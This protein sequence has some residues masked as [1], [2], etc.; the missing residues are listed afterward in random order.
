MTGENTTTS[1]RGKKKKDEFTDLGSAMQARLFVTD[2]ICAKHGVKL[3]SAFDKPG[4][5]LECAYEQKQRFEEDLNYKASMSYY[6]KSTYNWLGERSIY[7]DESLSAATFNSYQTEDKET[8]KNKEKAF[9]IAREYCRGATFNTILTG[10]AGT[11]KSHLAKAILETVNENSE[12]YRRCLFV[13]VDEIMRRIKDSFNNKQSFYTEQFVVNLLTEADLLVL[14]DI[15]AETGAIGTNSSAS[16][17]T[18]KTLYAI[19]NGRMNKPTIIT[20][21]LNAKGLRNLYDSKLISRMFKGA[22]GHVIAFKETND[23]RRTIDF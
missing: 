9:E 10:N 7:L 13:S 19:I 8:T 15:G 16:D 21:N 17:F 12:P 23:K 4:V 3:V 1:S 18:T 5:C 20:T 14:D 6:K 2:E 22:E 11:G